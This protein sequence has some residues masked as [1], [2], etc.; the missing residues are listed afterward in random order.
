MKTS[1]KPIADVNV[2]SVAHVRIRCSCNGDEQRLFEPLALVLGLLGLSVG[3]RS[4]LRPREDWHLQQRQ[5]CFPRYRNSTGEM[6]RNSADCHRGRKLRQER[7]K[8]KPM[9]AIGFEAMDS[10]LSCHG[11]SW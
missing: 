2:I 9:A 4:L 8:P 6:Q 5:P 7:G 3:V 1:T 10:L 11:M